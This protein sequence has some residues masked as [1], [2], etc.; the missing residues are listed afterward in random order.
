[1]VRKLTFISFSNP[2]SI[3]VNVKVHRQVEY[4]KS[5]PIELSAIFLN[6]AYPDTHFDSERGIQYIKLGKIQLPKIYYRRIVR[7]IN[8]LVLQHKM[9]K[10]C[11]RQLEEQLK[12]KDIDVIYMRYSTASI[13]LYKFAKKYKGKIVFEHNTKEHIQIKAQ[14][15]K[16]PELRYQYLC[17]K[18]LAKYIFKKALTGVSVS[19]DFMNYENERAGF[20][21]VSFIYPN[22]IDVQNTKFRSFTPETQKYKLLALIGNYAH[23]HGLD[24]LADAIRNSK[25]K[26][27]FEVVYVGK[28]TAEVQ[29]IFE[30]VSCQFV[31]DPS[32]TKMDELYSN[33]DIAIGS[34]AF[35]RLNITESSSL[36]TKEFLAHG[37]PFIISAEDVAYKENPDEIKPY[38][39]KIDASSGELNLD[40][41]TKFIHSIRRDE[42]HPET[43]HNYAEK[44][45]DYRSHFRQMMEHINIKLNNKN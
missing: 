15:E 9:Q 18:Y 23:W 41:V 36:K 5:S 19:E 42:N 44:H 31:E 32:D 10:D 38:F 4:F 20:D 26:D 24:L 27:Q 30:G 14:L 17:E 29:S 21:Y 3:G 11:F 28:I 39:L 37:I 6:A 34:L 7:K 40:E 8:D 12:S 16:E 13:P 22:P 33:C 45:L 35:F 25:D 43:M 1:L 2:K